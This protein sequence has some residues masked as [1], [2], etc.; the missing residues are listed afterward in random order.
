M[1]AAFAFLDQLT[2]YLA[3]QYLKNPFEIIGSFFKFQYTENT[4]VA[5]SIPI[6][7]TGIIILNVILLVLITY[8][9]VKEMDLSRPVSILALSLIYGGAIGNII[10]RL[11][12]GYVVDFISIWKWPSFNPADVYIVLGI[13]LILLFYSRIKKV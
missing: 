8:F 9:A 7:F 1:A 6:P 11:A 12:A 4:G 5:F 3:G 2:K 10:D 13:L